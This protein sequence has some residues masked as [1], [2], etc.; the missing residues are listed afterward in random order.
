MPA[1]FALLGLVTLVP[2]GPPVAADSPDVAAIQRTA[3]D[4]AESWYEGNP[5]KMERALHP[6]LAK[7]VVEVDAKGRGRLEHMGA[8]TLIQSVRAGYG[9]KIVNVLWERKREP[10]K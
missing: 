4:Y 6:D 8:L 7:R 9:K 10:P 1:I 2:A 3:L 5:D